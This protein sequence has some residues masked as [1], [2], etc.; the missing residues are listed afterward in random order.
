MQESAVAR[1]W[2]ALVEAHAASGLSNAEFARRHAV[3]PRTLAW[4]RHRFKQPSARTHQDDAR[5]QFT[6]LVVLEPEVAVEIAIDRLGA[7]LLVRKA[8][9]LGFVRQI[10]EALA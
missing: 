4:W 3:N 1:R 10:L 6:E 7:R 5:P 8:A 2:R 9:D